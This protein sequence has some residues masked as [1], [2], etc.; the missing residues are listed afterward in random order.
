L[1]YILCRQRFV[2]D[3]LSCGARPALRL[4]HEAGKTLRN[5]TGSEIMKQ[6]FPR[7]TFHSLREFTACLLGFSLWIT[8][9][10]AIA[11]PASGSTLTVRKGSAPPNKTRSASE[12]LFVNPPA[13]IGITATKTDSYPSSPGN[14]A[15][16]EAITYTVDVS[17]ATGFDALGVGFADTIDAN[18][19]LVPLSLKVS[20]LAFNDTYSAIQ[21]TP[22]N[23]GAPGVLSNDTGLP[24]P[25]A[26]PIAAGATTAGGTV[27]L[28]ANGSFTYTPPNAAFTGA[29]TFTYTATNGQAPPNASDAQGTVTIN[30]DAAPTVSSTTPTNGAVNQAT[31]T[32]ISITFSEAVNVTGNW[33]TIVCTSSGTRNVADTVVTPN[34]SNT[35]FTINPNTDFTQ[36]ESCTVTIDDAAI[37][38]QDTND[39][40]DSMA[41]DY[42]FSF[43]MDAAPSVSSTTPTNGAANIATNSNITL[44][45][46]ES[47]SLG[48]TPVTIACATSG[49]HTSVVSASPNTAFTINPNVDFAQ[50]ELCT[51]TVLAAQVSDT[52]ANDPPNDMLADY[53]FSFT[54]D[55]APSVT[56]TTPT[57]GATNQT[58]NTDISL[59]FS[60]SVSLGATPVTISCTTS[61]AHTFVVSASPNTTFTVNPNVDFAAGET[62]TVTVLAAQVTDTD[63]GDPPDNMAA[64][65]LFSFSTDAAPTVN[66]TTPTN[67]ATQVA[68]N[69][70]VSITFS[71]SV[72]LGATPV[73]ISCATSGSH[74]SVVSTG[75]NTTF[76][77]NPDTDFTNGELCTVT[78]LAAQVTDNDAN[79]PPDNMAANF[80]F[81]FT[82]DQSPSVTTTVPANNATNI[83]QNS[84]VT[85]TF[86]ENV[87]VA[88]GG[89]T[90]NCGSAVAFTPALPQSNLSSLVLT[91]T[92]GLPAG[93]N[94]TVTVDKTKIS[95]TDS[96][97]PPDN[98]DNDFV[99]TFKVKPDAVNDS[100]QTATGQTVLGNVSFN[101]ASIPYSVSTNDVSANAFT[102][103]AFDVTSAN[104]GTVSVAANGQFTYNPPRGFEGSDT[105][106][107]TISRTD[108]GGTDTA[109]VT[110][111]VSGMIWF[112]QNGAAACSPQC[113]RLSNPYPTL[114]AF[115]TDNALAGGLNPDNND[116]IF[117]YENASGYSGAVTLRSGQKLIGQDA[118]ATL[119]SITGLTQF[120]G[121]AALP[122]MNAGAP[123]A[124]ITS[125]VMLNTNA[126][127]RGLSINSTT[128]T[129]MNDPAGAITGV[130]VSEVIVNTTTGTAIS[131]S[132]IAGTL[133]FRSIS[134]NGA[135]HGISLTNS[136]G[137]FTV[138]GDG[139]SARNGSG[140]AISNTTDDGIRLT[141]ANNVT[142]KSINLNSPG[143]TIDP[144]L[145]NNEG[146]IGEHGIEANGG[147][148]IIVS[149]VL[150]D[151]PAGSGMI[152]LNL[153]GTNRLNLNSLVTN[154]DNPAT[155][156]L[157]LRNTS[158]FS[159]TL[160]EIND[161]DFTNSSSGAS[162]IQGL[163]DGTANMTIEVRNGCIFEALNNQAITFGNSGSTTGTLT[164]L[165]TGNTFQNAVPQTIEIIPPGGVFVNITSEN[166]V[167]V[168]TGGGGTH[169]TTVSNN[170]FDNVAEDGRVANTSII[171][172]QNSGGKMNAVVIGNTIQNIHYDTGAGGRHVIGHVFEPVSYDAANFSNI[173][174]ENNT[175]TGITFTST[176][177]EFIFID[178][179]EDSSG[180]DIKILGNN[181][182]MPTSASTSEAVELRFR[183]AV[184]S[185][186]DV[187]VNNNGQGTGAISNTGTRFF[188]IDVEESSIANLTITN[189]K[190]TNNNGVPGTAIEVNTE[191]DP[192]K[193]GANA[194][195]CVN[196]SGNNLT[197]AGNTV[198]LNE[199]AGTLN[200]TQTSA[201]GAEATSVR[202]ANNLATVTVVGGV[203]F[204]QPACTLPSS[205]L[206]F[207]AAHGVM[208]NVRPDQPL[209]KA[210]WAADSN[211]SFGCNLETISESLNQSQ[212]ESI[213]IAAIDHWSATGLTSQQIGSL[214][215]IKF[216]IV[217]LQGAYLGEA[218]GNRILVDKDAEGK[219]WFVDPTPQDDSEF[220]KTTP[221]MRRY[222]DPFGAAAG[223]IDLLTATEHEMG[224]KLGLDDSYAEKDRESLM[225]GYLTVGERR[226]PAKGQ[227]ANAQAGSLT[228][229]HFLTLKAGRKAE[230]RRQ[231]AV[232]RKNHAAT[233]RALTVP[234]SG[235]T[236]NHTI[237][238]LP[239][240]K[241]VRITFQVTVDSPFLGPNQVSNQGTVTGTLNAAP[242]TVVTNDPGTGAADDATITPVAGA[243][244]ANDDN[245]NAFKNTPLN[246]AAPGV[247][248]ND[249]GGPTVSAVGG[250]ADVTDP[251]SGCA[252]T[253][254]GSVTVNG[255]GSFTY[256]PPN[257]TFTGPDSFTYTATNATGSDTATVNITVADTSAIFI[258]EVLFNPPGTDAPN[259][260]I[261]LRGPA[262]A[263]IPAGTYLVA[264][265]GDAADNPGDVQTIINLSGLSFGSNGF[266][267]IV[268]QGNTYTTAAGATVI[269][270]TTSG[271]GG[272]PGSI[273]QAD[274][275]ATDIEDS[276]VTFMLIQ[277]GVAPSL[278]NDIDA[279][280]DGSFD[281][282]VYPGW[283]VR[284]SISAMNASALARAYG[285]FSFR[286]SAGTGTGQGGEVIV[287]FIPSYVGRI[288]DS[289]GSTAADWVSSG[290]LG[291]AAPNW[292][293][294]TASETEPASFASKPLNHIGA[295][296]FVNLAPVNTVPGAQ[297]VN[298]D[299][300]LV[301]TGASQI[302]IAD[303]DA[304]PAA[305]KVT[306]TAVNGTMSLS[307]TAGLTFTPPSGSNDGTNDTQ[308]V[309]TGTISAIN[310]ALNNLTFTPTV[311]FFSLPVA[312]LTI[313][314]EDQGNTGVGGNKTDSDTINISING[315]NDPPSFTI[316]GNPPAVNEDA[317]AQTANGFATGISQGPGETGQTLTFNLS[318]TGTTGNIAFSSGPAI[319]ATTGA[320][321]Y[322]TSV[323]TNG[324]ATFSVTLSDNGSNVAP[325]SNTSGAQVFTITVNAGNDPPTFQI[326][327]NPPAVN[328]DAPAQT[329]NGF[330]TN[331]QPGPVTATDEAGQTLVGYTVTANGT[332]G[333]LTFTS[334]PSINNAGQLTYTPT[335]NTSGTATFNVVATDSGSGTAPNVN[336][337]APVAF[338]ITVTGQ[339]DAPALDNTGNM[340]LTAINEDVA[341]A[342]N[343]GTLVGDIIL[344]AGGDRITD[345]DAGALEGIAVIAVDNTNGTWQYSINNGTNWTPFGSPNATTAR[346]LAANATTRVRFLPNA[347]FNGTVNPGITFRAW[348]QTSGTNGNTA[349]VSTNGTTTA[350]STATET[351]SVTVNP[352]NDPP[353]FTKGPDQSVLVNQG[354]QIVTPWATAISFGPANETGQT[355]SFQVTGNTNA[356]LFSVAPAISPTGTLTYTSASNAVGS[357]TITIALQD[358]G[359]GTDTSAPQTFVINVAAGNTSTALISSA[360]SAL[361]GDSV[362][363]TA[364]VTANSPSSGTP[365]GTVDFKDGATTIGSGTLNGSGVATFS[366]SSLTVGSH[367]ITAQYVA[368]ASFNTSTS[369][370][371]T[372]VVKANPTV[373]VASSQNPSNLGATVTFTATVTPPA[374]V[375]TT[376]TGTVQF[377]DGGSNI[378]APVSCSAAPGNTCTAQ[379]STS[380]LTSG[381]HVITADYVGDANFNPATGTLAGGQ[382]ISALIRF[383]SATFNTTESSLTTTITVE[384]IGDL[385]S[386]VTVD[387]ATA[388]DSAA[389]PTILP[390]STAGFVSAR[391]DFTTALGTLKFA[392]GETSKTFTVLISQDNYVEGPENLTL[393]LSNVSSNAVLGTPA[394]ATLTIADDASE[395]ATN[396]IDDSQNF[397]RQNYHDFLNREPVPADLAGLNFWT[398]QIESCGADQGC[399]DARRQ[400]VSAA[401]FLSIEFQQTGYF[402]YRTY[403]AG[404]GNI[405]SPSVP[406]PLRYREFIR[407]TQE[408]QKGVIVGQ[409]NWQAQL[410]ANKQAYALAFVKRSEF[411]VRY[412]AST[413]AAAFVDALN[414]NAGSVLTP[415][416]RSDLIIVLSPDPA[417]DALRSDVLMRVAEHALL[418]QREMNRAF[419]LMQYFGYLRRNPDAAPE[420]GLNFAG[421]DFWL[422][423]L[424]SFNGNFIEAE[425]VK[426]FNTSIEYRQRFGP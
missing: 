65:F 219:G 340:S 227:A 419:V 139:T 351:A 315:V 341:A 390:C 75:P 282:S 391:C 402:A 410:D 404:F 160:F 106:N 358:N 371:I 331:F 368:S 37:S 244:V 108:G 214:R 393:T 321:T 218:K 93:S 101:T 91:P 318:P 52:D 386:T 230:G 411:L 323:N 233:N 369:D 374:G 224:H 186:V 162:N 367:T 19:T 50:N 426:A 223:R 30:V 300:S 365:Q 277:S 18:T 354:A 202:Q 102:V 272:L 21:N 98:M 392:P 397:V 1:R 287:P 355:V 49:A 222:T 376:P 86:S 184:A 375:S 412:P 197:T 174:F 72:N 241:A 109:T 191:D 301:F 129:G 208:A 42:V 161:S 336:Q 12:E 198:R 213:V 361:F 225:Y 168:L 296:N 44:N 22:L 114:A 11:A 154:I 333:N 105:F 283:S 140:G 104:G 245:Y 122:A 237:G 297:A 405:N 78:V 158:G 246:I 13:A 103:T 6:I 205:P 187:Q 249:F 316:A 310:T 284:D 221:T 60:E 423:K 285:A 68:N 57:N 80:V 342:S 322:T 362:T 319:N 142:L 273:F 394:T 47:V 271:F 328:E 59:T 257:A 100:V 302:S 226:V 256:T 217:D 7:I 85:I 253:A 54:S 349:D 288:G 211:F 188:R 33:F 70:N 384:R 270:G 169:N 299:T 407:D 352:V 5:R 153:T 143:D 87:N 163:N 350:F 238:T 190:F 215:A 383:S 330:A 258:N 240:G 388:D 132:D 395:P 254:G 372:Q 295:S 303:G 126:T 28:N 398:N 385:T 325:N 136:T 189:N 56:S 422:N 36:A 167:G 40:P 425:M 290:V 265:E 248:G 115:N 263:M 76:T 212:L 294:G 95:D 206:L 10:M 145:A 344:S 193:T 210:R 2:K 27:T 364:T 275:A 242:F 173:R 55:A 421:Y 338:T 82:I 400:H 137:S 83:A 77:V 116:N 156:G 90:I 180:G 16:G 164:T 150:I 203:A 332:T 135:P 9:L 112:I 45:F 363:F 207:L 279:N 152:A 370:P 345:A 201:S 146:T 74:T 14:A 138:T 144:L 229:P 31:N 120:T 43:T 170:L 179:R 200:V 71:E 414:T 278:T 119:Y 264:M 39:P 274:A 84:T 389:T 171:R 416:E 94:C 307:G 69:A 178:Y 20:P 267:V 308:M 232:S 261:E 35:V 111:N 216:E 298:E 377:K 149:G 268:Q 177:R 165:I 151:S 260:Y 234:M 148:N 61:G 379:V 110:I 34:G 291:G 38:D 409:G 185:T 64:N 3:P 309:F 401:F 48:A 194:V 424:N 66:A 62:C 32:N 81:S 199:A 346:L 147:S 15:P 73:T 134:A 337:S 228:G 196:I 53:V 373:S 23:I 314:T 326:P 281:G 251:F 417:D 353:S 276:S 262:S 204:G 220:G 29:D 25:T 334:G 312:S 131:L 141:N 67:G 247:L 46:S 343:T 259:E 159:N 418:K 118:A 413:S 157:Y 347:N 113:G 235:E 380:S 166:N 133:S 317:G 311:N 124:N 17:N 381:T 250:C 58:T 183:S 172:T 266:L 243:P 4:Y 335:A 123:T 269:T 192:T 127:V 292:T 415:S 181:W 155:H 396:P 356:A 289:T 403:K 348:D 125:T 96:G 231:K 313:L 304:G 286:N 306:L 99:F 280:D 128:G 117:I 182:N 420:T 320:L 252:T 121:H 51:V 329:V 399:R 359:G 175:A 209:A 89:V 236:V 176:N 327:S 79:D 239:A 41:A 130:N 357:A 195:A 408:L 382:I 406:V 339:N 360:N 8:P 366:T 378:G 88:A 63:S 97:D 293:L 324:T 24:A 255:N 387:Y 107:Y 305:V 26:V 92:G